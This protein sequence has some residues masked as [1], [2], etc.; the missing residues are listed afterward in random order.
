MKKFLKSKF[1]ITLLLMTVAFNTVNC[2]YIL[3]P[4]RRGNPPGVIDTGTLIMDIL[5]LIPGLI[6]GA[7][8]LAVDFSTGSI[9]LSGGRRER[10]HHYSFENKPFNI[11]SGDTIGLSLCSGIPYNTQIKVIL[12]SAYDTNNK[13]FL[14]KRSYTKDPK[15]NSLIRL[16]IPKQLE[17]GLYEIYVQANGI[18]LY[19][20][21]VKVI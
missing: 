15:Q 12:A 17:P 19:S 21:E 20:I 7:I 2:G 10:R 8:A 6:P 4:E 9:Y 5:W 16:Y 18:D 1:L 3:Y 14:L 13:V 11:H